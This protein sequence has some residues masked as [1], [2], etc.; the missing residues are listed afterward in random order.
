LSDPIYEGST[1]LLTSGPYA[2]YVQVQPIN[3]PS[4]KVWGAEVAWQQR[5]SFLPGFWS[6]LGIL[7][8]Y[9]YTDSKATFLPSLGRTDSPRL[10]RTTPHEANVNL[11]YDK[12]GFSFRGALTYN[13]ATLFSYAYQD[14]AQGGITG[15]LGDTYINAHTQIDAQASYTLKSGVRFLVSALN[16]NNQ[17]FGFY[18]GSPQY[19]IQREFYGPTVFLGVSLNR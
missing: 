4:A 3:G 19:N 10:Q 18:N 13:S 7:A 8:N 2:G 6:G 1:Q 9:T 17:V 16:I 14:G 5:L 12:G 11:T 15:P